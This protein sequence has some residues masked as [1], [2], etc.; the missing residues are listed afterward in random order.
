M[1]GAAGARHRGGSDGSAAETVWAPAPA[2]SAGSR[3]TSLRPTPSEKPVGSAGRRPIPPVFYILSPVA[4]LSYVRYHLSCGGQSLPCSIPVFPAKS[5][6]RMRDALSMP[7]ART[8]RR[9]T[10]ERQAPCSPS[11]TAG[12]VLPF[13]DQA[14]SLGRHRRRPPPPPGRAARPAGPRLPPRLWPGVE[15]PARLGDSPCFFTARG[16]PGPDC[17]T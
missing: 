12:G 10:P 3:L 7:S 4:N 2:M 1:Q 17:P 9:P 11:T 8:A 14:G 5:P 16:P 6:E 15:G 13:H